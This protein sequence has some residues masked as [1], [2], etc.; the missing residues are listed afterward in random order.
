MGRIIEPRKFQLVA[1]VVKG[2]EGKSALHHYRREAERTHG[3]TRVGHVDK[4]SLGTCKIQPFPSKE[5]FGESVENSRPS[6]V[7]S[8]PEGAKKE[9]RTVPIVATNKAVGRSG[10]KS[11]YQIV[12]VKQGNQSEG[13]YGGKVGK[14]H[15]MPSSCSFSMK[16]KRIAQLAREA[17]DMSFTSLAHHLDIGM[18]NEASKRTRKTGS[19][20]VDG[21][22]AADYELALEDNL[23]NLLG[24]VKS[25]IYEAPPVRRVHIPKRDRFRN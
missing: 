8:M 2:T 14:G 18:L 17:P 5:T 12:P 16:L 21:Q 24:R 15:G 10:W 9:P 25:G 1:D 20:G 3:V 11:E 7:G 19:R 13:P 4:D 23:Q 22:T 6:S